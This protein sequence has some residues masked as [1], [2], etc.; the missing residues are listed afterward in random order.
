M[1]LYEF[2]CSK[3]L[4][5]FEA[6]AKFKEEVKCPECKGIAE[7]QLS[8][9]GGYKVNGSNGASTTPKG[10]GSFRK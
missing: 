7:R 9:Y 6:I 3:C 1:P 4:I 10:S 2:L 8:S 5:E